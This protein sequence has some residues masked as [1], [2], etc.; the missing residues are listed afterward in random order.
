[1]SSRALLGEADVDDATLTG[2]VADLLG[3][4]APAVE[5]RECTVEEVAYD[6]PAITTAGRYW[7]SG[8]AETPAGDERFRMFV[9]H[10]RAWHRHPFFAHVPPEHQEQARASVPWRTEPLAYASDLGDRL[11]EGLRMPR[12]L[13]VFELDD[14]AATVWLE[15]VEAEPVAWDEARYARA[16]YLLGRLAASPAVAPLADVGGFGPVAVHHYVIGRLDIQVLP[17]L[18]SEE[19]WTHPVLVETFGASLR[20]RLRAA[21]DRVPTYAAELATFPVTAGHGDASPNNLLPGA[22]PDS[23]CLIDYGFWSPKPVGFDLGQLLV[24]EVQLGRCAPDLLAGLDDAIVA[25]YHE[26]LAAEGLVIPIADLR[27]AHALHLLLFSG[28]SALPFDELD[29]PRERLEPLARARA[30][31]TTFC[32][33]LVDASG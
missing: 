23:F 3:H 17:I 31:L 1:M 13:G 10:V 11:P 27:R 33:D 16:A 15:E 21:A 6:I 14:D 29:L 5:L 28:L 24:G 25:A 2:M 20:D 12:A 22:T 19:I 9:K 8:T 26:G 4:P 18:R 30:A 32:L 7:V